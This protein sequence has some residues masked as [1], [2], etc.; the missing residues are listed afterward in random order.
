MSYRDSASYGKRQE[1]KAI[2]KLLGEGFDVYP[3]LVDDQGID[4]IVRINANRYLDIQIKARSIEKCLLK[5]RGF[6]PQLSIP[7]PRDNYFFILYSQEVDSYWIIPSLDIVKM[8]DE[9]GT[10]VSKMRSGNKE[11]RF[12]VRVAGTNCN[13]F[14]RFEKYRNKNGFKLLK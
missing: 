11:G 7:K 14:E 10:N 9:E 6:F 12:S 5:D 2:A 13:P 1:F 8:A 3:T 4:C